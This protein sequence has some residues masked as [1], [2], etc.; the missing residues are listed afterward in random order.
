MAQMKGR[1][2]KKMY[3][4]T[5]FFVDHYSRLKYIHLQES[6]SLL[7]MVEVKIAFEAYA[8]RHGVKISH[9]HADNGRFADQIFLE[10]IRDNHQTI[11]YCCVNA[12]IQNGVTEKAIRDLKEQGRKQLIHAK[13]RWP[14]VIHLSLWPYTMR[15][16]V[17][18]SNL[19]P[20]QEG[21]TSP[22]E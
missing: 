17:Y 6:S 13:A 21:G 2:T 1:L 10:H 18:I 15:N 7:Q 14:E 19:M 4:Y 9:Y 22:L 8:R 20:A 12:H 3:N 11:L 5:T 16:A